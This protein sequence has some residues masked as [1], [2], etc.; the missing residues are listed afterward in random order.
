MRKRD[1]Q[2]GKVYAWE[3]HFHATGRDY[4]MTLKECQALVNKVAKF[5]S[6]RAPKVTD[7]RGRRSAYWYNSWEIALPRWSRQ[8]VIILHELAHMITGNLI[9]WGKRVA[10]HGPEF[11]G[12]EMYLLNKYLK[13]SVSELC[14]QAN[15]SGIDFISQSRYKE[16]HKNKRRIYRY[17]PP[18]K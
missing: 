6:V 5:Y 16:F 3:R 15:D 13:I 14:R 9:I 1:S 11:V 2:R 4:E 17:S 18:F 8:P 12:V 7:G 10:S